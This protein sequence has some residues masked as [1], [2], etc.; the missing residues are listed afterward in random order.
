MYRRIYHKSSNNGIPL[1]IFR[2]LKNNRTGNN[3]TII[4]NNCTKKKI[5]LNKRLNNTNILNTNVLLTATL[6]SV[7]NKLLSKMKL[8]TL[9]L[10][11]PNDD[12]DGT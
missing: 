11:T 1:G 5:L 12:D 2:N 10:Y 8:S 7:G 3:K 6:V 9:M 4:L